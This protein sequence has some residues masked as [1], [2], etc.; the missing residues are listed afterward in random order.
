MTPTVPLT[1]TAPSTASPMI[2]PSTPVGP[3]T[4][5]PGEEIVTPRDLA[6][7]YNRSDRQVRRWCLNGTLVEF[8]FRVCQDITG[9]WWIVIPPTR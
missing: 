1:P 7:R 3:P 4:T 2:I 9:R 6:I 5:A 8:G